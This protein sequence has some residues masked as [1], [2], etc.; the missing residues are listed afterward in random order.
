MSWS[1]RRRTTYLS[2]V[3]FFVLLLGVGAYFLFFYE[4]AQCSDGIQNGIETGVDCGGS[5]ER[6]CRAD[7]SDP[8]VLWSRV[9]EVVPGVYNVIAYVDNPN[10]SAAT[11][12]ID[13]QFQIFDQENV[14]IAER[15]GSIALP[16]NGVTPIFEG[17]IQTDNAVPV[18]VFFEIQQEGEWQESTKQL[19]SLSVTDRSLSEGATPKLNAVIRNTT[20]DEFR[21]VPVVAVIFDDAGNVIASSQ[22][23]VDRLPPG[24]SAPLV[25]TWPQPFSRSAAQIDILPRLSVSF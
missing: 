14:V 10:F 2:I 19:S 22:T 5:C 21:Q 15:T 8:V 3:G 25:F 9:T 7:L 20:V 4:P 16:A 24:A 1:S 17:G 11:E 6:L 18:R 23:V 12:R 13:Y